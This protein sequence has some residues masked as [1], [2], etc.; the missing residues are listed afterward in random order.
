MTPTCSWCSKAQR[1]K[2]SLYCG[3]LCRE[4]AQSWTDKARIA[5]CER[6]EEAIGGTD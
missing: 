3:D 4:A 2:D 6:N 5:E 1:E